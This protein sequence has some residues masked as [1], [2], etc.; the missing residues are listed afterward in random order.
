MKLS[1]ALQSAAARLAGEA[2]AVDRPVERNGRYPLELAADFALAVKRFRF[3]ADQP[4]RP[5]TWHTY[6]ELFVPLTGACRVQMG[7]AVVALAPG[8]VLVMD[9]Q[10][11]HA[12]LDFPDAAVEAVVIRFRP[13][14]V[15]GAGSAA[16][17]HLL[18]LPF[19]CQIEEQ[20][21]VLRGG[22][23]AAAAVHAA[24]A[25]LFASWAERAVS[26]YGLTGARGH[27]LVLLH[28]LARRFRAAEEL[29][30]L[31]ARQ[32]TRRG[33][34]R[35]VF[36]F[37]E[38]RFADRIALPRVAALAGLSRPQFHTVFKK[39][40]GTTLV[41]YVNQVRLTHAARL[42]QETERSVVEIANEVGFADQSYFDRRFRRH[43]GRTPLQFRRG[44]P[45]D[46]GDGRESQ[47][48]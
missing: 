31:F 22:D 20:P 19:Y 30:D 46:N 32:Q 34:L 6:L 38:T 7:G 15:R 42:L 23:P 39:A 18:L 28:H 16:A 37:I 9:H 24:L 13:E 2:Y 17:D 27:F 4:P 12:V 11:L 40:T 21:H 48:R 25:E 5:L 47:H 26:P 8:D 33:R 36:E 44:A 1:A 10:K 45:A 41:D 3:T 14:F 43:F 35:E 29:Q